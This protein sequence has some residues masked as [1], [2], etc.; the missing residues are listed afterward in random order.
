MDNSAKIIEKIKEQKMKPIPK[1]RFIMKNALT[2]LVFIL[3]IILGAL[4]FSVVL[5]SIQQVDFN[6][7][8]ELSSSWLTWMLGLLPFFWLIALLIFLA[9]AIIGIRN[10]KK[11]Y[12]FTAMALVGFSVGYSILLG[13]LFFISG[14]GRWLE[15]TFASSVSIYE[16]IQDKKVKM[17]VIP[18]EG[19]LA[20]TVEDRQG[21][22]FILRDFKGSAWTVEFL[23]ADMPPAVLIEKGT[24][25]K[26]I[27]QMTGTG[28]FRAEMIRPWGG[29]ARFR[30]MK[31]KNERNR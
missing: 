21:E 22:V 4:A 28:M 6:L 20:G 9:T 29:E 13:T 27:G 7:L 2:W 23:D 17:W 18:D 5:F 11:G 24:E 19:Y 15:Y 16:S 12:K 10:S 3:S 1:W 30:K 26:I 25:V 8:S 31:G 14:G